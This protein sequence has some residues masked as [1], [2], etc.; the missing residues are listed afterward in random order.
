MLSDHDLGTIIPRLLLFGCDDTVCTSTPAET[1]RTVLPRADA[2][3]LSA[4]GDHVHG[5]TVAAMSG[6][7]GQDTGIDDTAHAVEQVLGNAGPV[8]V[9]DVAGPHA[10]GG[11][12]VALLAVGLVRDQGDVRR[13]ARVVLDPLDDVRA[14]GPPVE[15]HRP[16]APL[17]STTAVSDGDPTRVVPST[18]CLALLGEG[19]FHV[20]PALP[21]VV[22]DGALQMSHTGGPGL[23]GPED[24]GLLLI[25]S[26]GEL[27]RPEGGRGRGG[28]ATGSFTGVA[29]GCE[30]RGAKERAEAG[31]QRPYPWLEH[32]EMTASTAGGEIE[33]QGGAVEVLIGDQLA[34]EAIDGWME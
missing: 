2:K 34:H 31:G 9:D 25:L 24:D 6:L 12:D 7:G 22:V 8:A 19:E 21:Q 11:D 26:Q 14:R 3:D 23:V 5:Q 18:S 10:V 13:A 30:G 29:S 15:V 32:H 28:S 4:H 20:R 16:D 27:L 1:G 17:V 33:A